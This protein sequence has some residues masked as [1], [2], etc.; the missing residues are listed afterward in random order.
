MILSIGICY[1][2]GMDTIFVILC[3]AGG[4][5]LFVCIAYAISKIP[6]AEKLPKWAVT[7]IG[8]ILA[9]VGLAAGFWF[10]DAYKAHIIDQEHARQSENC[11]R[12]ADT[13][14][15][16]YSAWEMINEGY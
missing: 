10:A 4:I 13:P 14:E 3:V 16:C 2:V 7:L 5:G 12:N 15:Q 9:F 11:R 1:N 8:F 6:K